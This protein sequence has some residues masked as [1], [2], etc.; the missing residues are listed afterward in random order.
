MQ[1]L[2]LQVQQGLMRDPHAAIFASLF[3]RSPRDQ[4]KFLWR[5]GVG[6]SFYA[7]R[8]DCGKF[9]CPSASMAALSISAARWPTCWKELTGEI[10]N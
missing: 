10:R 5:D 9:I 8:L 7:K 4:T 6:N 2:A 1:G 3:L